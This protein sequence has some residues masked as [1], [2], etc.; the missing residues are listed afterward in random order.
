MGI[1]LDLPGPGLSVSLE[2]TYLDAINVAGSYANQ[3]PSGRT[4][5]A[6][7]WDFS[8]SKRLGEIGGGEVK[9]R[10][11][12]KNIFDKQYDTSDGDVMP[13][14]SYKLSLIWEL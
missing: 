14:A 9:A 7:I 12:L 11:S 1:I 5:G 8:A 13:G 2:G 3:T 6:T 4:G 10:L